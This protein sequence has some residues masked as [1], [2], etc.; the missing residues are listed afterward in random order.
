MKNKK[1]IFEGK[2]Y[3]KLL[4]KINKKKIKYELLNL[5]RTWLS[6]LIPDYIETPKESYFKIFKLLFHTIFKI[7][8]IKYE[9]YKIYNGRNFLW[10]IASPS[11]R[12]SHE[13]FLKNEIKSKYKPTIISWKKKLVINNHKKIYIHLRHYFKI[14]LFLKNITLQKE[15]I[16]QTGLNSLISMDLYD[17]FFNKEKPRLVLSLKDFQ[18]HE[19]A[20]IQKANELNILTFSTQH[21]VHPEFVGK[22]ERGG[23][24]I[25]S[26]SESKNII[27]WGDFCKESY[28]RYDAGK[29]F[30]ISNN[31]ILPK[32]YNF[33]LKK[34]G[35]LLCLGSNRHVHEN[36]EMI[37][38]LV[39]NYNNIKNDYQIFIRSHPAMSK[40]LFLN[41]FK[42]SL[43]RMK[44]NFI[45]SKKNTL[46]VKNNQLVAITGLSGSYY[47]CLYLGIKTLFFDYQFSLKKKLP[48]VC[49]NLNF[50]SDL[51]KSLKYLEKINK[52]KWESKTNSVLKKVW[53][54]NININTKT[55]LSDNIGNL[56]K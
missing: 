16:L 28:R 46:H 39:K 29:K 44:Y 22:N 3:K 55:N 27:L 31:F 1:K 33:T 54:P 40:D 6:D 35:I 5:N 9:A 25:F 20:I 56:F 41:T 11:I 43:K 37:K 49:F 32:S 4:K 8:F 53:G 12:K 26:N 21:S 10:I 48:R 47:D 45:N 30:L 13:D 24:I 36:N 7:F 15:L 51:E 14:I 50:K 2:I 52:L 42:T 17:E 19:N 18:R 34:K 38:L 23:N